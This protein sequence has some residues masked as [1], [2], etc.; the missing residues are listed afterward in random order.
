MNDP[1]L[2]LVIIL[3]VAAVAVTLSKKIGLGAILGLLLTGIIIGPYTPGQIILK[4]HVDQILHI[5]EFGIVLLLF[6]IGL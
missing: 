5:S 1:M 3:F 2:L 4:E 6:I